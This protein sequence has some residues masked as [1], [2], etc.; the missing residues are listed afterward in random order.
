MEAS[1]NSSFWVMIFLQTLGSFDP[2]P[3]T[4]PRKM[5]APKAFVTT[6]VAWA[7]LQIGADAG[8]EDGASKFGW[9]LV[10]ASLVLG[11]MGKKLIHLFNWVAS[12]YGNI[13]TPSASQAPDNATAGGVI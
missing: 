1:L 7:V 5:P 9:L 4:G 12:V 10:L 8:Y 2:M 13:G 6:I 3:G 11:P